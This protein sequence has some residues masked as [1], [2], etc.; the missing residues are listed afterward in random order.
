MEQ[1]I[2]LITQRKM[3]EGTRF[4]SPYSSWN[5]ARQ[6]D[7]KFFGK[8]WKKKV[9]SLPISWALGGSELAN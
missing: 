9:A 4:N 2:S 6:V 3:L 8:S 1:E 5:N 7:K